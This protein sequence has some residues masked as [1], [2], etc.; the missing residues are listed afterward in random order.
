MKRATRA[1]A[2]GGRCQQ[3]LAIP[4]SML[5][6]QS[7]TQAGT[8]QLGVHLAVKCCLTIVQCGLSAGH[9]RASQ[10]VKAVA[11]LLTL[12]LSFLLC[13]LLLLLQL[14]HCCQA[15]GCGSHCCHAATGCARRQRCARLLL[16][17]LLQ[18]CVGQ[19]QLL[20]LV[21]QPCRVVHSRVLWQQGSKR[22]ARQ[23]D[24]HVCVTLWV[25]RLHNRQAAQITGVHC[26]SMWLAIWLVCSNSSFALAIKW[27]SGW[28]FHSHVTT[29]AHQQHKPAAVYAYLLHGRCC[30][31]QRRPAQ[32]DELC[33]LAV[34]V[35]LQQALVPVIC[36]QLFLRAVTS[37]VATSTTSSC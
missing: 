25:T 28:L 16:Q 7:G 1:A 4:Q 8:T 32:A 30:C 24:D 10:P 37:S 17:L 35:V 6:Q 33:C 27:H 36:L 26:E 34:Q 18:L 11:A 2:I 3:S 5:A 31:L 22:S 19:L 23:H 29:M 15:V 20:H 21:Q 13:L 12:L 14:L 9:S